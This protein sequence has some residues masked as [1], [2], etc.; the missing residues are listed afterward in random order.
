MDGETFL[1]HDSGVDDEDRFFMF[2]T[3]ANVRSFEM[4]QLY[5]DGTFSIAPDLFLQVYTCPPRPLSPHGILPTT[6]KNSRDLRKA[7]QSDRK[8]NTTS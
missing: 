5:A 6:S 7:A 1:L 4:A 2:G 8:E 3:V